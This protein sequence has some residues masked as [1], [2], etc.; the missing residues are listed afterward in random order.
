MGENLTTNPKQ[1][2][3]NSE[4]IG[5]QYFK[6]TDFMVDGLK[7]TRE[8]DFNILIFP[9]DPDLPT[10]SILRANITYGDRISKQDEIKIGDEEKM[11]QLNAKCD[12][13]GNYIEYPREISKWGLE[14]LEKTITL[15]KDSAN[16]DGSKININ[17]SICFESKDGI[18]VPQRDRDKESQL[19][20][21]KKELPHSDLS[22]G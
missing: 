14:F 21:P 8:G 2:V 7:P 9:K 6:A 17:N 13:E 11:M 18:W 15:F 16:I 22:E 10:I 12:K 3:V 1:E 4:P 5:L 20:S 19:V